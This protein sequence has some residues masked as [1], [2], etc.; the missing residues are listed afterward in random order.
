MTEIINVRPATP[1]ELASREEFDVK[2]AQEG[3]MR[4]QFCQTGGNWV[5]VHYVGPD[6]VRGGHFVQHMDGHSIS[7]SALR[8]VPHVR[9]IYVNVYKLENGTYLANVFDNKR[10]AEVLGL[11][12]DAI[13]IGIARPVSLDIRPEAWKPQ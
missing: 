7:T 12:M 8:T 6:R 9:E 10:D 5:D 11:K 1:D 2:A 4:T 13:E 3:R